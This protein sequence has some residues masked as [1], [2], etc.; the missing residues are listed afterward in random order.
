[1]TLRN[2]PVRVVLQFVWPISAVL[3]VICFGCVR[4]E[5]EGFVFRLSIRDKNEILRVVINGPL[6]LRGFKR[7]LSG[8][9]F[10]Y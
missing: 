1:M 4:S 2:A 7:R 6:K 10:F 3:A 5:I 8:L 9:L